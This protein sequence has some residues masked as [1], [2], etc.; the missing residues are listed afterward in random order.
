MEEMVKQWT[1]ADIA[2]ERIRPKAESYRCRTLTNE[3]K[4]GWLYGLNWLTSN[5]P[6]GLDGLHGKPGWPAM[7]DGRMREAGRKSKAAAVDN[8]RLLR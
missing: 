8:L 3:R 4:Y 1:K 7:Q 6:G 5:M 2:A